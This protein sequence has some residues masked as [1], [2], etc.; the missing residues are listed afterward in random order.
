MRFMVFGCFD[1]TPTRRA[2]ATLLASFET[3]DAARV[4]ADSLRCNPYDWT[5]IT[6]QKGKKGNDPVSQ[7]TDE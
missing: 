7:E 6:D 3:E 4:Y 5:H 1:A 2:S